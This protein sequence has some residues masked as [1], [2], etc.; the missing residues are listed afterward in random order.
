LWPFARY[1]RLNT[2]LSYSGLPEGVAPAIRP[3]TRTVTVGAN[4]YLHPQ[5]VLKMDYMRFLNDSTRDRFNLGVGFD[6]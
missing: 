4:Y 1:E 5:V 3:D 2:A 6:F